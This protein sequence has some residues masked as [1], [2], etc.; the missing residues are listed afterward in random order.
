MQQPEAVK[1]QLEDEVKQVIIEV[2]QLEDISC[3]NRDLI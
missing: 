1:Q 3:S 2:L